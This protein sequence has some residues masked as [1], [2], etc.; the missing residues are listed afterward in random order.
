MGRMI[1]RLVLLFTP[2]EPV[3]DEGEGGEGEF[4]MFSAGFW[5][6]GMFSEGFWR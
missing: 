3:E 6:E 5:A 2:T 4:E 1:R